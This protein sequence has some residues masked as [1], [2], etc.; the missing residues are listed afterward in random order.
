MSMLNNKLNLMSN[1]PNMAFVSCVEIWLIIVG[2][3]TNF[4]VIKNFIA[5]CQFWFSR[6]HIWCCIEP[7]IICVDDEVAPFNINIT[8]MHWT[9]GGCRSKQFHEIMLCQSK[10]QSW[11]ETVREPPNR[12]KKEYPKLWSQKCA[13]IH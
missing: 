13:Y 2:F 8:V 4:A 3:T 5:H 7:S 1:I 10:Q 9:G 6:M 12:Y 11:S